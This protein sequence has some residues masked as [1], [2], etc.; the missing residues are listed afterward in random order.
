ME[1]IISLKQLRSDP[2]YFIQLL[3]KGYEVT[4][5]E[6]RKPVV[7]TVKSSKGVNEPG[8]VPQILETL[9]KLSPIKTPNPKT[10][11]VQMVKR[12]KLAALEKKYGKS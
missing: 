4:I 8:N 9:K 1:K 12:T 3:K 2:R 11:T 5:T 10:N 7:T 6:H